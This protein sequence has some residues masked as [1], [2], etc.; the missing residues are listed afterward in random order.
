MAS[1][2]PAETHAEGNDWRGR[3]NVGE[4]RSRTCA[5]RFSAFTLHSFSN[6]TV[7]AMLMLMSAKVC[8]VE[9]AG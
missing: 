9:T 5:R 1:H 3:T 6:R 8:W 7:L 2:A 4:Q